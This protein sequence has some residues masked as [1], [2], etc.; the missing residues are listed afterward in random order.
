MWPFESSADIYKVRAFYTARVHA[1]I[2]INDNMTR[3]HG[4]LT[5]SFLER[6]RDGTCVRGTKH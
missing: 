1:H 3:V 6:L 4:A 2:N 5:A